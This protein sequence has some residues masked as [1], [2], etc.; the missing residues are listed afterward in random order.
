MIF[1]YKEFIDYFITLIYTIY[2]FH[3]SG[4]YPNMKLVIAIDP[5]SI[6][7]LKTVTLS[8]SSLRPKIYRNGR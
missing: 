7:S 1:I 5:K 6:W 4:H 8:V 2:N 3:N